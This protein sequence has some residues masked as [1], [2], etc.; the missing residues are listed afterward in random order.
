MIFKFFY[1]VFN[2]INVKLR[3]KIFSIKTGSPHDNF[4]IHGKVNLLNTNVKN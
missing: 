3:N 4:T 1:R 2:H